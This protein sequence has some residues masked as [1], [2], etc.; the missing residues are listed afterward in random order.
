MN[1]TTPHVRNEKQT[2]YSCWNVLSDDLSQ[3]D[4]SEKKPVWKQT[5][6]ASQLT[7]ASLT[8]GLDLFQWPETCT[9]IDMYVYASSTKER[10]HPE[11]NVSVIRIRIKR[12]WRKW[13]YCRL[14][15]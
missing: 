12:V 5:I 7:L 9:A 1:L 6:L 3:H 2:S 10:S 13:L 14:S 8:L 11:G 4:L 15:M